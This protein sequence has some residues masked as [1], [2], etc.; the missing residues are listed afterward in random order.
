MWYI[1]ISLI[2]LGVVAAIAGYFRDKKLRRMLERGEI[3]EIPE[4]REIPEV[5]CGQYETCE[6][7]SLLA[8]VSQKIEYYNDEELDQFQGIEAD[9]YDEE[10][11]EAFGEVLYTL[12]ETEVAGWLR[13]LQLR[14]IQL[15]D[16]L[17]DEAF[18]IIGER[19]TH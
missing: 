19:R 5:C 6:R 9:A 1:V 4:A 8:A 17:K 14:G 3:P 15:P 7:D 18:L 10:A 13:S 2:V 11:I 12:R 16:A